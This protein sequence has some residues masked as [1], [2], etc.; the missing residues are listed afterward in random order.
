MMRIVLRFGL[1]LPSVL[2]SLVV[3]SSCSEVEMNNRQSRRLRD[4]TL[5]LMKKVYE[6][7]SVLRMQLAATDL[8]AESLHDHMR[9]ADSLTA[10]EVRIYEER[11]IILTALQ[12]QEEALRNWIVEEA[13]QEGKSGCWPGESAIEQSRS[14]LNRITGI[15]RTID[16]LLKKSDDIQ[17]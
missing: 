5:V 16:S 15:R 1:V 9:G 4:N 3:F 8:K 11:S 7:K 12:Q 14:R 2:A 17:P 13:G 6:T 10:E